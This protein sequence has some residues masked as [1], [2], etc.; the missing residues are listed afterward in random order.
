MKKIYVTKYALTSGV[1][2]IDADI[3]GNMA[4][5]ISTGSY[6]RHVHGDEFHL[7]P[8]DALADC[9]RRRKAKIESLDKQ[10]KKIEAMQFEIRGEE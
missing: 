8:D 3:D 10:R 5:Y 1:F 2:A 7:T 9:E 4:I 6:L